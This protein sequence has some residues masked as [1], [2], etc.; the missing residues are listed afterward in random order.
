MY[1]ERK[2]SEC[3]RLEEPGSQSQHPQDTCAMQ[4]LVHFSFHRKKGG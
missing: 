3:M 4:H 1:N 2:H